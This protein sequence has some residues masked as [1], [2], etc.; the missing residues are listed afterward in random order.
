VRSNA[1]GCRSQVDDSLSCPS[2]HELEPPETMSDA[3][4]TCFEIDVEP[5]QAKEL[6]DPNSGE[7]GNIKC[8]TRR[9]YALACIAHLFASAWPDGS[10][11]L[12]ITRRK[13]GALGVERS[14]V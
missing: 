6:L 3:K 13:M 8:V 5:S 12:W 4:L 14:Q 7:C 11:H 10:T 9:Y 1:L 2:S